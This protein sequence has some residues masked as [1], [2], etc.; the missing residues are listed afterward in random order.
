MLYQRVFAVLIT[1]L[2]LVGCLVGCGVNAQDK[3]DRTSLMRVIR[4]NEDSVVTDV[5]KLIAKGA[6]V[7][8][9]DSQGWTPL[10]F[11][12]KTGNINVV[13]LLINK[14]AIIDQK[15]RSKETA[16]NFAATFGHGG[17]V[18]ILL[19]KGAEVNGR[20]IMGQTPL[21]KTV[22]FAQSVEV[23]KI[24][25][26]NGADINAA[27]DFGRMPIDFAVKNHNLEMVK[28]LIEAR[29][30]I[31]KNSGTALST[32]KLAHSEASKTKLPGSMEIVKLLEKAGA[33]E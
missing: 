24:L 29:A 28:V 9:Q 8:A 12:A 2:L 23:A 26:K 20:S 3:D 6:N 16:L 19:S 30:A 11:A 22:N 21:L 4:N 13:E 17:I 7:N 14:G 31:N 1:V 10:M 15:D 25:L 18:Q 27:D 32:L 33:E 5:K